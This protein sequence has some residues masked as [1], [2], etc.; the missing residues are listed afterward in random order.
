M[1]IVKTQFTDLNAAIKSCEL[2]KLSKGEIYPCTLIC[3]RYNGAYSGG[4]W[5]AFQLGCDNIPE[6]IGGGDSDENAFWI[7]HIDEILPVGKGKTL[8]EGVRFAFGKT[9]SLL[10]KLVI[11]E[12]RA[13]HTRED[14]GDTEPRH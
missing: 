4:K 8:Q 10:F 5:L 14:R 2:E 12:I 1:S 6:E 7:D 11:N 3:D 9:K 13:A